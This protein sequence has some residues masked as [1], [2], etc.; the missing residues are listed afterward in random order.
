M[1]NSDFTH[2]LAAV[3]GIALALAGCGDSLATASEFRSV[4]VTQGS[5]VSSVS[6]T[7]SLKAV[8]TVDVGTQVSGLIQALEADFNS[9]VTAGQV[10]ARI[11]PRPFAA[12][13]GQAEAELAV[14]QASVAIQ[15]AS[16][17]EFEAD[18][19]GAQAGFTEAN[20]ELDRKRALLK[21]N[22]IPASTVD[23]AQALRTQANARVKAGQARLMKQLAQIRLT[24]ARVLQ[25]EA[26]VA[27]RQLDLDYTNIRSPVDGI[28]ISRNV[29]AGQTVAASLQ[30]PVLFRI[31]GDLRQMEVNISVDEADIGRVRE[32]QKVYFTVDS[33]LNRT[34]QGA[35]HQIRMSGQQLSNVVTYTVVANA[36][37]PDGSLLPGMTAN[38]TIV[39]DERADVLRA[40]SAA[41]RLRLPGVAPGDL[42]GNWVWIIGDDGN[43]QRRPIEV[44][45]FNGAHS[46]IVSGE[47]GVDDQVIVG[48][49]APADDD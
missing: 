21:R 9:T 38:V 39:V 42:Q 10:I 24:E 29:D 46:E 2:T 43:P 20:S 25:A 40:P 28:V 12:M 16:L 17:K 1:Q 3:T 48:I 41:L 26:V 23:T 47:V 6:S 19:T 32:G 49:F 5:I 11:D 45:I 27:Q 33:Y 37:N 15:A 35:V 44:G 7:G 22:A 13:L 36:D 4:P 31:A 8:V 34:F 30:A 18:L 14:A